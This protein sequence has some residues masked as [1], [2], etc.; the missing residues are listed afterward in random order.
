MVDTTLKFVWNNYCLGVLLF[1]LQVLK[2]TNFRVSVGQTVA[3]VGPS[4]SG[5]STIAKLIQRMYDPTCGKVYMYFLSSSYLL[6]AV[7]ALVLQHWRLW[8]KQVMLDIDF[9][10]RKLSLSIVDT[11]ILGD[12]RQPWPPWPERV[13]AATTYRRGEPGTCSLQP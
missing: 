1:I 7:T 2:S 12:N 13:L 4:G 10:K 9:V 6:L 5:K 11:L 8:Q 3:L